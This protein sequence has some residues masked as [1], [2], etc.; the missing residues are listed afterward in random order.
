MFS[1]VNRNKNR[2]NLIENKKIEISKMCSI[3]IQVAY[4]ILVDNC[5]QFA[6]FSD[7]MSLIDGNKV[8]DISLGQF[9]QIIYNECFNESERAFIREERRKCVNR[10]AAGVSRLRRKEE[11]VNLTS[12]IRMLEMEKNSL[13]QEMK[14]LES[15]IKS[16]KSKMEQ[17]EMEETM[18]DVNQLF[19]NL[20]KY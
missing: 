15:E 7:C 11:K 8:K 3:K 2:N 5:I 20:F 1:R 19:D 13:T 16:Y 12:D 14:T 6:Q 17:M 9:N 10:R 4:P 18:F